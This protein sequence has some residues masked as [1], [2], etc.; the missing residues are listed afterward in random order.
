MKDDLLRRSGTT[1]PSAPTIFAVSPQLCLLLS[2]S[3]E[4]RTV[5]LSDLDGTQAPILWQPTCSVGSIVSATFEPTVGRYLALGFLDGTLA[6]YDVSRI[7]RAHR[8]TPSASR[9]Y[10]EVGNVKGVHSVCAREHSL[11]PTASGTASERPREAERPAWSIPNT[12]SGLAFMPG[13]SCTTISVGQDGNCCVVDFSATPETRPFVMNQWS[14][15]VP[16][17]AVAVL[18]DAWMFSN[19][20]NGALSVSNQHSATHLISIGREDGTILIYTQ[21]GHLVTRWTVDDRSV[22]LKLEWMQRKV[23]ALPK[24]KRPTNSSQSS[25][26][27]PMPRNTL[28]LDAVQNL[29]RGSS[30]RFS[31]SNSS[32]RS[33]STAGRSTPVKPQN[34]TGEVLKHHSIHDG[35][36]EVPPRPIPRRNG[37][38]ALRRAQTAKGKRGTFPVSPNKEEGKFKSFD[39]DEVALGRRGQPLSLDADGKRP[40]NQL[41]PGSTDHLGKASHNSRRPGA[42][43]LMGDASRE[44]PQRRPIQSGYPLMSNRTVVDGETS[45]QKQTGG[46]MSPGNVRS[47]PR[48]VQT[49]DSHRDFVSDSIASDETVI[50]WNIAAAAATASPPRRVLVFHDFITNATSSPSKEVKEASSFGFGTRQQEGSIAGL[51]LK[52]S[53]GGDLQDGARA[54]TFEM[55]D[56][57]DYTSDLQQWLSVKFKDLERCVQLQFQAQRTWLEDYI[58]LR[59]DRTAG[60]ENAKRM[61]A[62]V[63][64]SNKFRV[65][66]L[67]TR[68]DSSVRSL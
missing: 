6:V 24:S 53:D 28:R 15:N 31:K 61:G 16:A 50:E 10:G 27:S 35:P 52:H 58:Q 29:E 13:T 40:E 30:L 11:R 25:L 43:E 42:P 62:L 48:Q 66:L 33:A 41:Q 45:R 36:P 56:T 9:N 17:T 60:T 34:A 3:N 8:K 44:L 55:S 65:Q 32:Y 26:S 4:P 19:Q 1:H 46:V 12:I 47:T 38:L 5:F 64:E 57:L 21:S 18:P 49:L 51:A 68:Q 39:D 54:A 59:E 2:A 37:Q 14:V 7:V 63:D 23:N 22:I 67:E 20:V